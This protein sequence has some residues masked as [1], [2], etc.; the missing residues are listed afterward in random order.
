MVLKT[1][2]YS[3]DTPK[4][5]LMDAGAVYTG[6]TYDAVAGEFTG[7]TL[8]GA[9]SGGNELSIEI[10]LRYPEL[11]GV[12]TRAKEL[13]QIEEQNAQLTVNVKEMT[14]KVI[15]MAIA[16]GEIDTSDVNYDVVNGKGKINAADYQS[17]IAYVGRI[18][19]SS[20]PVV[21]ILDNVLSMEG[22]TLSS[23]DNNEAIIPIIFG[24]HS[25]ADQI[26]NGEVPYR[27][28]YPK[29]SAGA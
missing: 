21:I 5:L 9:T 14:A 10:S 18:S 17:N 24:A 23:E 28:Y 12:K 25:D 16:G 1:N 29:E 6:L 8:V 11:D 4:R 2:G 20:K 19:G 3:K 22:F 13:A 15:A 26:A 27:I 7:G